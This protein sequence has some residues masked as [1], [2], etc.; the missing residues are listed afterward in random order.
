MFIIATKKPW[1]K[2]SFLKIQNKKFK[3]INNYKDLN[4]NQ[5]KKIKPKIIFFPH[6]SKKVSDKIINNYT[7]IC[8]HETDLPYGRGGSP[9]QNLIIRNKKKTMISALI[10]SNKIDAGNI[11]CKKPMRL[12]GS[13]KA[14]FENSSKIIFQMI[15]HISKMKKIKSVEQKGK[16]T[17][18]KRLKNNSKIINNYKNLNSLYNHIRM[19]DAPT[20]KKAYVQFKNVK[21]TLS[22]ATKNNKSIKA[23]ALI[24]LK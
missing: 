2:S 12:N 8:F 1:H 6:W 23:Q 11:I 4:I 10:M 7:C 5:L 18:F 13:A 17:Y 14:I 15:K 3:L 19:L 20:Y 21:V 16:I 9:I 22:N 24:E